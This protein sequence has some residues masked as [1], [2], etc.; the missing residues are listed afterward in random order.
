MERLFL[1]VCPKCRL[2]PDGATEA[3]GCR[4]LVLPLIAQALTTFRGA[5][6]GDTRGWR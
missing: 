1:F 6:A 3:A 4:D 5:L 2:V